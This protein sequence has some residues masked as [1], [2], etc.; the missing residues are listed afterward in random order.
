MRVAADVVT[1][2]GCRLPMVGCCNV[3]AELRC[4]NI[5]ETKTRD[6]VLVF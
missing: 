4:V 2:S 1:V 5:S 6:D 3:M